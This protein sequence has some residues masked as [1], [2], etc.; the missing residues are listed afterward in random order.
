MYIIIIIY[1]Y[2]AIFF[3]AN[4]FVQNLFVQH[5]FLTIV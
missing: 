4:D 2:L 3:D 5:F 1:Y